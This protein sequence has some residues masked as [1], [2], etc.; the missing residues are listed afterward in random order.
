ML[1][2]PE[3]FLQ[4]FLQG[5]P[6]RAPAKGFCSEILELWNLGA[7]K[8]WKPATLDSW[9]LVTF[10]PWNSATLESCNPGAQEPW[11]FRLVASLEPAPRTLK[12]YLK[13]WFLDSH[14]MDPLVHVILEP[15]NLECWKYGTLGS[16][17]CGTPNLVSCNLRAL[18]P[19]LETE[20]LVKNFEP[21]TLWTCRLDA[22]LWIVL[23]TLCS[24]NKLKQLYCVLRLLCIALVISLL[25]NQTKTLASLEPWCLEPWT[26]ETWIPR[27]LVI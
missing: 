21:C 26:L 5:I 25:M 19:F 15:G 20:S 17:N 7:L 11:N 23:L 8:P 1:W 18:L 14:N 2:R 24:L 12:L 9:S 6:A 10:E 27:T 3:R 22:S 13:L 16:W 4:D